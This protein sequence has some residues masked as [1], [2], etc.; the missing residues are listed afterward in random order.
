[1]R[2]PA[3]PQILNVKIC[4]NHTNS[5]KNIPHHRDGASFWGFGTFDFGVDVV[6]LFAA[7][8]GVESLKKANRQ[9]RHFAPVVKM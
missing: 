3:P 2:H 7:V 1:M 9:K 4:K 6:Y 5:P 8:R